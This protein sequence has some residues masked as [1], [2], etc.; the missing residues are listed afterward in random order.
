M[1]Q[2]DIKKAVESIE[3]K[4]D[5]KDKMIQN[6][7]REVKR[8]QGL[9]EN[10]PKTKKLPAWIPIT[11]VVAASAI[12]CSILFFRVERQHKY[13]M[14]PKFSDA[15]YSV[16]VLS[17]HQGSISE[18]AICSEITELEPQSIGTANDGF[19]FSLASSAQTAIISCPPN[20]VFV[21]NSS[22]DFLNG[23]HRTPAT[24]YI[25]Q[26]GEIIA[27]ATDD[28]GVIKIYNAQQDKCLQVI[29]VQ[30]KIWDNSKTTYYASSYPICETKEVVTSGAYTTDFVFLEGAIEYTVENIVCTADS[31]RRL[32]DITVS[33]QSKTAETLCLYTG[34]AV[35]SDLSLLGS[36]EPTTVYEND[37]ESSTVVLSPNET[38]QIRF[39][40]AVPA[41]NQKELY[42]SLNTEG[43]TSTKTEV[44]SWIQYFEL[45]N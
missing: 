33:V 5:V 27:W 36:I 15:P 31:D 41:G 35:L 24:E 3:I 17:Y 40:Y 16:S 21:F 38:K 18:N 4:A 9:S 2:D 1:L 13:V 44:S 43:T 32:Y 22:E 25:L 42:F 7:K 20:A 29:S 23:T 45:P 19:L 26:G 14:E 34:N 28:S 37:C 6:C 10:P 11:A 8:R 39:A 12:L 30:K